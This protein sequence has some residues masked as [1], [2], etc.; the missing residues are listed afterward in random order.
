MDMKDHV[1][2][3][4]FLQFLQNYKFITIP[5]LYPETIGP[6]PLHV[7]QYYQSLNILPNEN[8]IHTAV[9]DGQSIDIRNAAD[10]HDST[11]QQSVFH[12]LY[13]RSRTAL[14]HIVHQQANIDPS[15]PMLAYISILAAVIGFGAFAIYIAKQHYQGNKYQ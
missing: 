13:G 5:Q 1:R 9:N 8:N 7:I 4:F 6:I 10:D 3:K 14:S 11:V 15:A 2:L 12:R